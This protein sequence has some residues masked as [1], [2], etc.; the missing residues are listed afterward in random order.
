M[1]YLL[2]AVIAVAAVAVY[3]LV[4]FKEVPG[5]I[6]ERWGELEGLP[7]NLGEWTPDEASPQA[8][9]ARERGQAREVRTWRELGGGRFGRDRLLLQ[10]RYRDLTSGAIHSSEPDVELKR[11][12]IKP[13]R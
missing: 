1:L 9:V 7:A 2:L 13:P 5:A 10:V 8:L 12:R 11:R 6:S 3:V 4:V